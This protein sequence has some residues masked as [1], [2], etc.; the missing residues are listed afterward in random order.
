MAPDDEVATSQGPLLIEQEV[1]RFDHGEAERLQH[2]V[3]EVAN[4]G[5]DDR[6]GSAAHRRGDNVTVVVV[7]ECQRPLQNL[8][9]LDARILERVVHGSE[10]LGDEVWCQI[11][12]N[13]ADGIGG[14]AEDPV[15]PERPIQLPLRESQQGVGKGDRH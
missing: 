1:V 8:P 6:I 3:G 5:R 7:R 14:F 4:V 11:G 15:R 10:P 9:A 13:L 2:L 12:M